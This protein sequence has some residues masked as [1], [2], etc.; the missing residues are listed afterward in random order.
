MTREVNIPAE[1]T[2]PAVTANNIVRIPLG[3]AITRCQERVTGARR[4]SDWAELEEASMSW[5][6]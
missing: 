2:T 6:G 3:I 1:K 5:S 4:A